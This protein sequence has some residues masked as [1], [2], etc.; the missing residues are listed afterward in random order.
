MLS[1][2]GQSLAEDQELQKWAESRGVHC[3]SIVIGRDGDGM[4]GL[5]AAKDIMCEDALLLSIPAELCFYTVNTESEWQLEVGL[6]LLEAMKDSSSDMRTYI[7]TLPSP[8]SIPHLSWRWIGAMD[9]G[10]GLWESL[11]ETYP[12]LT[13]LS[14][15]QA[16]YRKWLGYEARARGLNPHDV[17]CLQHCIDLIQ[18]RNC[19]ITFT[20]RSGKEK[21]VNLLVPVFDMMN[22]KDKPNAYFCGGS[23]SGGSSD[24]DQGLDGCSVLVKAVGRGGGSNENGI[25]I[26]KGEPICISY[27]DLTSENGL[28]NYGFDPMWGAALEDRS[29]KLSIPVAA[30]LPQEEL[31]ARSVAIENEP[32]VDGTIKDPQLLTAEESSVLSIHPC[33]VS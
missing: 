8:S 5:F 17:D 4:R 1:F 31:L 18:T 10:G 13:N 15:S 14:I 30:L 16:N 33:K 3:D 9:C 27:G 22:H 6:Q 19:K 12:E 11:S 20:A 21:A 32:Q 28:A 25:L 7:S 2:F 24:L 23:G 29:M 26:E